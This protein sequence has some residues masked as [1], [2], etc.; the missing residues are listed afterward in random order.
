MKL[1]KS[2]LR[3][4]IREEIQKEGFLDMF[5]SR[6][7][8]QEGSGGSYTVEIVNTRDTSGS[9]RQVEFDARSDEEAIE[10]AKDALGRQEKIRSIT[11]P[12]GEPVV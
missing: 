3:Q 1:T 7:H 4:L 2:Q 8:D 5:K 9:W 12:D 6:D 10:K 11:N